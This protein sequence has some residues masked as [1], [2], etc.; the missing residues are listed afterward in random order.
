MTFY[1][2]F[3]IDEIS[4]DEF[5][6][7]NI[8]D[9]EI[10]IIR[11]NDQFYCIEAR[12]SHAGAPLV[13]GDLQGDVLRCPWHGSRFNIKDGTVIEGPAE[14]ALRTYPCMIKESYLFVD[15]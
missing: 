2:T 8:K 12:C 4:N 15:L 5:R 11:Q 6:Q 14:V 1:R 3:K 7:F 9:E 13:E 10:L